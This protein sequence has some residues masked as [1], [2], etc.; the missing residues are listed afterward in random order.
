MGGPTGSGKTEL[1]LKL[2]QYFGCPILSAD[3]R[4]FYREMSIG[5][6]KPTAVELSAVRHYFINSLSIR[7]DY[8]VGQFERDCIA[9]LEELHESYKVIIAVG[10]TGLYLRAIYQGIDQFPAVEENLIENYKKK[11]A[12][13]GITTLQDEL[14]IK[15]PEY[16]SIVD[17]NNPHR[18]I[19]ALS[20]IASTGD[21]FSS[22]R[23][24]T[25]AE[26]SF[27]TIKI[28]TELDRAILYNRINHRVDQMISSGLIDEVKGLEAYYDHN[29]LNTVGY[30]ELIQYL[31]GKTTEAEAISKIKQHTRN[32][33]KRQITWFNNQGDWYPVNPQDVQSI[34]GYI[35]DQMTK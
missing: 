3:S 16:A 17:L 9:L 8:S 6:A 5:T 35:E 19:R 32:Y 21:T 25:K 34:I 26:R 27:S 23:T 10:G 15:D 7:E 14:K 29:A 18:L 22:F 1:S 13:N 11:L 2:A 28:R 20:V 12:L 30:K 4:Q 33:A 24:G 31:R